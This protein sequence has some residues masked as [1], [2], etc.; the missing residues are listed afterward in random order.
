MLSI[1]PRQLS[2][3]GALKIRM[4]PARQM[5]S[6]RCAASRRRIAASNASRSGKSRFS[7]ISA[8]IPALRA[9]ARPPASRLLERTSAICAG[10]GRARRFDQRRHV[11]AA[12]GNE[13]GDPRPPDHSFSR[14]RVTTRGP[15]R[16]TS[17]PIGVGLVGRW[18]KARVASSA[19]SGC[20][21]GDDAVAAIESAQHFGFA[22]RARLG[23]PGE[24]RRD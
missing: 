15:S 24:H 6:T 14:P 7:T 2:T 13:N 21:E 17:W 10:I 19:D 16:A 22:H 9:S 1:R 11:R 23:E 3:K 12:P 8:A 5:R 4:K 20:D 18:P